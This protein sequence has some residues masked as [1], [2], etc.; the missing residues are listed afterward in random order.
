MPYILCIYAGSVI[1]HSSSKAMK[2]CTSC[3]LESKSTSVT[4][5]IASAQPSPQPFPILQQRKNHTSLTAQNKTAWGKI[6]VGQ[7][8]T[9]QSLH[10]Q[11]ATCTPIA[12]QLG[13]SQSHTSPIQPH[14]TY[15]NIYNHNHTLYSR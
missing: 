2:C 12:S 11:S 7:I 10:K 13:P 14:S 1:P 4:S 9:P 15:I 5:A 6:C 3:C 8:T